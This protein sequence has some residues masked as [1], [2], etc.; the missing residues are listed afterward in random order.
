LA[1]DYKKIILDELNIKQIEFI[2]DNKKDFD[3]VFFEYRFKP[4]LKSLGKKYGKYI[5]EIKNY[6]DSPDNNNELVKK[7]NDNDFG[8]INININGEIIN[9]LSDDILIE[10][11]N[12]SGFAF[13]ENKNICIVLD[14]TLDENLIEDGFVRE[15]ISKIQ[16]MRKEAK[17]NVMDRIIIYYKDNNKIAG[18]FSR[19]E[20]ILKKET[21]ADKI[22]NGDP[23][24][25]SYVKS[26]S[27]NKEQVV[28]AVKKI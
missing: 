18:I 16:T 2:D 25:E 28:I 12:K 23:D 4:N 19:N 24:S 8:V 26:W 5:P 7:I 3:N 9:L 15:L 27:I 14:I 6:L 20:N 17:F 1:D 11:E 22:I 10:K 21:L 13:K